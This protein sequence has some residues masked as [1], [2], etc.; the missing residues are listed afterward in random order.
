MR[1][2]RTYRASPSRLAAAGTSRSA[3]STR[4]HPEE[5]LS[6]GP[7]SVC[8]IESPGIGATASMVWP[9]APGVGGAQARCTSYRS[10]SRCFIKSRWMKVSAPPPSFAELMNS[11]GVLA[12]PPP[13]GYQAA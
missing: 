12:K 13:A 6:E 7:K 1:C 2:R 5:S 9:D 4:R 8:R 3:A 10:R 11:T